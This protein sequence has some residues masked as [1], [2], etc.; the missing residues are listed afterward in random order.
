MI[1][2]ALGG[3]GWRSKRGRG[4]LLIYVLAEFI[5]PRNSNRGSG[6]VAIVLGGS[7]GVGIG[8]TPSS[9]GRP[10]KTSPKDLLLGT[11]SVARGKRGVEVVK[12]WFLSFLRWTSAQGSTHNL[13]IASLVE[14][15]N[16]FPC[17]LCS[18]FHTQPMR[19]CSNPQSRPSCSPTPKFG[20]RGFVITTFNY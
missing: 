17:V 3:R 4:T 13:A 12:W 7:R 19:N 20:S 16:G 10:W 8:L 6:A 2:L 18:L 11:T 14:S 5:A 1:F 15:L 9:S